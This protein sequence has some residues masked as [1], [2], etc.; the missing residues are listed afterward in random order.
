MK[1]GGF[2]LGKWQS[3]APELVDDEK[4]DAIKAIADN[5]EPDV[6][7]V[8]GVSWD[9]KNDNFVF[10]FDKEK[11]EKAVETPRQLV[12]VQASIYDPLGFL[13][14]FCLLGRKL[15]QQATSGSPGWDSKLKPVIKE[16]FRKWAM[17]I[18]QL[19]QLTIP[20]C[21]TSTGTMDAAV[22]ELHIFCHASPQDLAPL[23]SEW[24]GMKTATSSS[25]SSLSEV[26]SC[27]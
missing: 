15:L 17:S 4:G 12:S 22:I 21:F 7:K 27:R 6:T 1:Q 3:N 9:S 20:R 18:V 23:A 5:A 8:P 2:S 14:P 24:N 10:Q 11:V 25:I 16:K 13:L 26:T 19:C